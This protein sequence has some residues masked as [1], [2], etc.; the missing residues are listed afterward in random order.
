MHTFLTNMSDLWRVTLAALILG[1]GIP[2]VFAIG[3]RGRAQIDDGATG[4][5]RAVALT[6]ST[7]CFALVMIIVVVGVLYIAKDFLAH[8]LGIHIFGA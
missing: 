1:A 4:S 8:R 3:I 6:V 7:L 2:T 5:A